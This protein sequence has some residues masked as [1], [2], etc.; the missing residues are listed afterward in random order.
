MFGLTHSLMTCPAVGSQASDLMGL[1]DGTAWGLRTL[2]L[3][4]HTYL[5]MSILNIKSA[6]PNLLQSK[7]SAVLEPRKTFQY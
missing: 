3:R 6:N 1:V 4:L 2:R 5:F 7:M